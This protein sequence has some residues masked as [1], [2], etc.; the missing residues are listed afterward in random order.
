LE[1]VLNLRPFLPEP[2]GHTYISVGNLAMKN[3]DSRIT[4]GYFCA[5]LSAINK[6]PIL[7]AISAA[8]AKRTFQATARFL[9]PEM[10][11]DVGLDA[12]PVVVKVLETAS[13]SK[14]M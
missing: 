4:S 3:D 6:Q 1:S 13:R 10:R 5:C 2:Q 12:T 8:K 11:F 7:E 14:P 9:M